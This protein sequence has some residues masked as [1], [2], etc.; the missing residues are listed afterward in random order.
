M[1]PSPPPAALGWRLVRAVGKASRRLLLLL[2][3]EGEEEEGKRGRKRRRGEEE[4][5][6]DLL[7]LPFGYCRS[8]D[9]GWAEGLAAPSAN[10][11]GTLQES[12]SQ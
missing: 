12:R 2:Q 10:G 5:E 6:E 11:L 1:L 7:L 8:G 4:E 3:E 9:L